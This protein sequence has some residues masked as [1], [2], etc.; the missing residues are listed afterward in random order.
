MRM[1]RFVGAIV[2]SGAGRGTLTIN[3][4]SS[5]L[6]P[7]W[8]QLMFSGLIAIFIWVMPESPRWQY[9]HGKQEKCRDFLI[10]YHGHGNPE[11]PWVTLQLSEYEQ[12]LELDG[13][14]KHW[15]DYR[16]LFR[17]RA[18][19]YR[20]GINI[21]VSIYGQWAGNAVISYF[22]SAV[23]D[24][25]GITDAITQQNIALGIVCVQFVIAVIGASLTD[26]LGRRFLLLTGMTGC[27][28]S[29]VCVTITSA[30]F[31]ESGNTNSGAARAN[32][33]FIYIF[34][35]IFSFGITPLQALYPSRCFRSRCVPR[36]W[37]SATW[38]SLLA[39]CSTS[40]PGLS[41]FRRSAGRRTSSF[42][43]GA[44]SRLRVSTSCVSRPRTGL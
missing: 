12:H 35:M 15:W 41:V 25:S 16:A 30:V 26:K 9:V 31:A 6:I 5:W 13:S 19:C 32:L 38:P 21:M 3:G 11:S 23:L 2:A 1:H 29:W 7:V 14:D 34:S 43:S 40:S 8:L 39:V 44:S 42:P 37:L 4:N 27:A 33:A 28:I 24:T 22:L 10:K 17:N 36:V 18:S 20:I